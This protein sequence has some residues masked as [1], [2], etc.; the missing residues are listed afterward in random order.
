MAKFARAP[1]GSAVTVFEWMGQTIAF[2]RTIGVQAPT[3]VAQTTPIHPLDARRPVEL[4]TAQATTMGGVT[5]QLYDLFGE[6]V[7]ARL[8]NITNADGSTAIDLVDIFQAVAIQNSGKHPIL[9]SKRITPKGNRGPTLVENYYNCVV[10][11]VEDDETITVG[12]MEVIKTINVN[13]THTTWTT[14]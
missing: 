13:F 12:T 9:I 4:V 5:L 1:G 8:A 11:T 7:W 6:K 2:A 10:S 14:A 3:P